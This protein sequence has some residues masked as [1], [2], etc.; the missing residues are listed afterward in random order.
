MEKE[1]DNMIEKL[2]NKNETKKLNSEVFGVM[3][4]ARNTFVGAFTVFEDTE[5]EEEIVYYSDDK[6]I[7]TTV[8]QVLKDKVLTTTTER[9]G[10]FVTQGKTKKLFT[11]QTQIIDLDA[12]DRLTYDE[13]IGWTLTDGWIKFD[14]FIY[15][16]EELKAIAEPQFKQSNKN[17]K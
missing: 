17:R 2:K 10:E 11:T 3:P 13:K 1:L 15:S 12:G 7:K 6:K 8:N 4:R 9:V 5:M 16:V 14:E